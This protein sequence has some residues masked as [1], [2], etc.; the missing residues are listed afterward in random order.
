MTFFN[1]I[2]DRVTS[3]HVG[4]R[5]VDE[6]SKT[7]TQTHTI[8]ARASVHDRARA[9]TRGSSDVESGVESETREARVGR[10]GGGRPSDARTPN[11]QQRGRDSGRGSSGRSA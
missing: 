1:E 3:R 6:A 9:H 5:G 7:Y 11:R 8:T 2:C 10:P 4:I